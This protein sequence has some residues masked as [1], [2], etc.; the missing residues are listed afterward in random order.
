MSRHWFRNW[1][2]VAVA[3]ISPLMLGGCLILPGEFT[4]EMTVRRSG[5]FSFSYQG[6]IQMVGLANI[7]NS[8]MLG[9]NG[10]SE[11]KATCWQ[12]PSDQSLEYP[13]NADDTG[14]DVADTG[15]AS[16]VYAVLRGV[17]FP[18]ISPTALQDADEAAP[19][20]E[21]ADE[22]VGNTAGADNNPWQM[23]ERECTAEETA[24]QKNEWDEQR[25]AA[26]KREEEGK[27]IAAMMLGGIDPKDPKTIERFTKEV[28]RLAA[29]HKVEH[30]GEGVFMIDYSTTG[31]LADDFAFPIIPRYAVGEP[32]IH[33]TRWDD[34]RVRVEAPA[35]KTDPQLSMMSMLGA[36]NLMGMM[37]GDTGNRDKP[38]EP[39]AIKGTFTLTT[40]AVILANNTENGPN[41]AGG[42][43]VL[44]WD[45]GPASYG[46]PMALLKLVQ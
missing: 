20:A 2:A 11:F 46:A 15:Q 8:E 3:V 44:H 41:A 38:A 1:G 36:G 30:L 10:S 18:L 37:G 27:K 23:T 5:D 9:E 26:K 22:A 35:F 45:I 29:W 31:K 40:D 39:V 24:R 42:M 13:D 34:G 33:V 7:L 28:A 6:Q 25:V 16:A 19:A 12:E 4:S 17:T 14:S 32:M 21:A 43:E